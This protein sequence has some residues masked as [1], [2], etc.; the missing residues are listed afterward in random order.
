MVKSMGVEGLLEVHVCCLGK[1]GKTWQG[2]QFLCPGLATRNDFLQG[3]SS[4]RCL[5]DPGAILARLE[6]VA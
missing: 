5:G 6:H 2:L 3:S 1:V 4:W